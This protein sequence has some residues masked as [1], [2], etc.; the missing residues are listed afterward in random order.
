MSAGASQHVSE[1]ASDFQ[2]IDYWP[3][4]KQQRTFLLILLAAAAL[5]YAASLEAIWFHGGYRL[6]DAP[7]NPPVAFR[8]NVNEANW[9]ELAL[10][11]GVGEVLAKRIVA[12]RQKLGPFRTADDL[13]KVDQIG[14][15][16]LQAMRALVITGFEPPAP[17][18]GG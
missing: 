11:P 8:V 3:G 6:I 15:A 13:I 7:P 1:D 12:T 2:W 5:R 17:G 16:K 14:R 9:P 18:S 4:Y 10:L